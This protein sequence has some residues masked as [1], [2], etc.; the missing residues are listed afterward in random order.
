[1]IRQPF[2]RARQR[3]A[4]HAAPAFVLLIV[5]CASLPAQEAN[6]QQGTPQ[7]PTSATSQ[8]ATEER[9]QGP[10][11]PPSDWHDW[12]WS[13]GPADWALV[14]IAGLTGF[15]AFRTLQALNSQVKANAD[16][17]SAAKTSADRARD[18]LVMT[19]RPRLKVGPLTVD[20]IDDKGRVNVALTNGIAYITNVG[21]LPA[22]FLKCHAEWRF[23]ETLPPNNPVREVL[24]RDTIPT[25]IAPGGVHKVTIEDR[26]VDTG[27]YIA[28]N[29][30]VES[31]LAG[32]P[33]EQIPNN[34]TLYLI[35]YVK[36]SDE[37]GV[38]RTWFAFEYDPE[39]HFFA[40][41]DHPIYSYEE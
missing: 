17:A 2:E 13:N 8:P 5:G 24:D 15:A 23:T 14:V 30:A 37:I 26:T 34:G 11:R 9:Q 21:V 27:E 40:E 31:F 39:R 22:T 33:R 16:A 41:V 20:G 32:I 35:G 6:Q 10:A 25:T 19:H 18:A 12:L 38:R 1:M 28:L 7:A 3:F 4:G 36:Y 29:N